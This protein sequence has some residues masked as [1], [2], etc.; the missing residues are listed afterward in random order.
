MDDENEARTYLVQQ[1]NGQDKGYASAPP[2][3]RR[4]MGSEDGCYI[5]ETDSNAVFIDAN[6]DSGVVHVSMINVRRQRLGFGTTVMETIATF[7]RERGL[8]VQV[9]GI[10][11]EA[12]FDTFEW[13]S[14]VGRSTFGPSDPDDD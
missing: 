5:I 7:A 11:N 9:Y 3:A 1:L 4:T 14:E 12:F 10:T 2:W 13:L 8:A 6:V